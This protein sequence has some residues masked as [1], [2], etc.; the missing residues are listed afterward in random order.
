[1]DRSSSK[2]IPTVSRVTSDTLI[3]L[4]Y[5][6][7]SRKTGLAVSRFGGLWNIEEE[8]RIETGET[9]VPYAGTNNLIA[10]ECVLLPSRPMEYGQKEELLA[11]IRSFLHRYVDLSPLFEQIAVHYVLLTW[12]YDAFG[13][14]P[15]LR[16]Q[17][18]FGTGKTRG[19]LAIG[20]LCNKPFFGSGASSTAAI[21]R[22]M[23]AFGGTLALDEADLPYSDARVDLVK[24]FNNG[25]VKGMPVLRTVQNRNKEFNPTAFKVF[26][27]KIIAMRQGF[28]DIA[29]ESRFFTEQTGTRPLRADIPLQLPAALKEEALMLRNRLLHFRFCEFF[30]IK[31]DP[32]VVMPNADPRLNQTAVSLLSLVDD[33]ELRSELQSML[34]AQHEA[35]LTRRRETDEGQ[36]VSAALAAFGEIEARDIAVNEVTHCF[37]RVNAGEP[38]SAKWIGFMLRKRLAVETRRSRGVY[39]VPLSEKTK[40][41]EIAH[42]YRITL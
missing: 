1:M 27:P 3:E 11:D 40:L 12:V 33:P 29:L 38:R 32:A 30:K 18:D 42:R 15:Y 4:V 34:M 21:F 7:Q 17:G 8:V 22:T 20:S 9:L 24:I 2:A 16:L 36:V 28:D 19:L 5:D 37:N 31:T 23:D 6:H 14:L 35:I 25:T 39:V 41:Q 10:N 13:E 26:G